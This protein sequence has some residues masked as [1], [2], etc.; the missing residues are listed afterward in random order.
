MMEGQAALMNEQTDQFNAITK[1]M[2]AE[3][4]AAKAGVDIE[5]VK[6]EIESNQIDNAVAIGRAVSGLALQ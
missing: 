6:T 3:A 4:K 1:R 2:E 5:K